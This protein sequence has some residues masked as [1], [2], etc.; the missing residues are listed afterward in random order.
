MAL[1]QLGRYDEAIVSYEEG[2]R[3]NAENQQI[4]Q[5]LEQCHKDKAAS[6]SD[7]QGM[8]GPQAMVKLMANPRIAGYFQDPK[9]RQTFEMCK[10]NP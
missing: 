4:K 5:A 2:L 10:Q 1:H 7:D 6:E 3:L 9:F 8:F